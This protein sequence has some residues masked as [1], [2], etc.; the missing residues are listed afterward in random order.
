M[1]ASA[2][3]ASARRAAFAP[4]A[5]ALLLLV[6]FACVAPA[7]AG[8]GDAHAEDGA[9]PLIDIDTEPPEEH[10]HHITDEDGD[11]YVDTPSSRLCSRCSRAR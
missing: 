1:G 2:R 11:T 9:L 10:L 6:A 5:A 7:A 3:I 4:R 8:A